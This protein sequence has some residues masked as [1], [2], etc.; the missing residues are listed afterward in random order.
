MFF[1]HFKSEYAFRLTRSTVSV[2]HIEFH[3]SRLSDKLSV[4]SYRKVDDLH[5]G[6]YIFRYRL[7]ESVE[8]LHLFIRFGKEDIEH[9]VKGY[10]YSDGCYCPQENIT[11]W[12]DALECSSASLSTGQLEENIKIFNKINMTDVIEK[13][14]IK[15]FPY[16]GTY[17]LCHYVIKNNQVNL[18]RNRNN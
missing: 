3:I 18:I 13:A 15:Y 2:D 17:A 11:Q 6:T 7:Y 10:V 16:H 12:Y 8:D 14:K 5:D 4:H 9:V 1:I